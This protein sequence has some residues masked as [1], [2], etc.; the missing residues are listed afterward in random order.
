MAMNQQTHKEANAAVPAAEGDLLHGIVIG[1]GMG[2]T[3]DGYE[4]G[5]DLIVTFID[6]VLGKEDLVS[7]NV[8]NSIDETIAELDKLL[9]EQM[10]EILH[11]A[12][13]QKLE[14]SWR[15][16]HHLVS[17]SETSTS[18]KIKV[19]SVSKKELLRDFKMA[20]APDAS[21]L[22]KRVYEEGIGQYGESPFGSLIGD[23]EFSHNPED[24]KLLQDISKV[25]A[26]AHAPFVSA[27]S[28][29]MFGLESFTNIG[30]PTSIAKIF[31]TVEYAQWK[32]FRE[33]EDSR[34]VGLTL[35]HVLG[36][37]PYGR[38]GITVDSF[39]YQ[40]DTDGKDHGKY[41]WS[42]AAYA[43]GTR[44]TEAFALH[45]WCAAIRGPEGGGKVEGLPGHTFRTDEGDVALK[46]P[47]EVAISDP[48]EK[49]LA[50]LGFIPLV[51]CA[52]TDHAAFF[53]A[54]SVQNAKSYDKADAEASARMSSQLPYI[55]AVSRFA[56]YIT[57]MMR[58]K[59][60]SFMSRRDVQDYLTSWIRNYVLENDDA[61]PDLKAK[62]P[63]RD[64]RIEVVDVPGKPGAYRAT[65][66]LRPHFQLDQLTTSLRMVADLPQPRG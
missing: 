12:E 33:S 27:A 40:E 2:R 54:Q 51:H 64:A 43:F 46:C 11:A 29:E 55:Y 21:T 66:F 25:A 56:H 17:N 14:G 8:I 36:R 32:S 28:P 4:R 10:N 39:D 24:L 3:P 45:G 35:P 47:T 52:G 13:F 37:L 59:T 60:G 19:L 15:G 38:N 61:G 34:Y 6:R 7:E 20:P 16:L 50:D 26:V 18:L 1:S 41:L 62:Q 49:E 65:G 42:N 53:S 57:V 5:K 23:F 31:D 58:D 63:L 22:Y 48:R 9:S 30:R 44:L